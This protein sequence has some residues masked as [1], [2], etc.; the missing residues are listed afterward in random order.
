MAEFIANNTTNLKKLFLDRILY[1]AIFNLPEDFGEFFTNASGIKDYWSFENLLY[2][3]VDRGFIPIR[4]NKLS[5]IP[6][7][8]E[9][10]AYLLP[11]PAAAFQKMQNLFTQRTRAGA[12]A[13]DAYL[14]NI[15][16]FRAYHDADVDYNLY[17]TQLITNFNNSLISAQRENEIIDVKSYFERMFTYILES[18][19]IEFITRTAFYMSNKVSALSSG[20][21][22]EISD[23]DPSNNADKQ[24]FLDSP[25][26]EFYR[27][28]AVNFGFLI[29][30][31]IPWRLNFDLSSPVNK[32][33]LPNLFD[34]TSLADVYLSSRFIKLANSDITQLTSLM[35]V[36][37][38]TFV[39][40]RPV[41]REGICSFSRKKHT[42]EEIERDI[43]NSAYFLKKYIHI[44]NK[45]N[46][47]VYSNN[48]LEKIIFNATDLDTN[49]SLLYLESKFNLPYYFEGST[50][51]TLIK[52]KLST[53]K[54]FSLDKFDQHVKMLI[55]KKIESIY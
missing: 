26:F 30:K 55:K 49:A 52:K 34:G 53:N 1:E 11:E 6:L 25:N 16:I 19:E 54:D 48:E 7:S 18:A 40:K 14:N 41:R 8:K 31:N 47:L 43:F 12:L 13:E 39:E 27:E 21:S 45:E 37:Y 10:N 23:L 24:I 3:K 5:L 22:L 29:D 32:K 9:D 2:G 33:E 17:V 46:N 28:A 50:T 36:G 38:N 51:Y 15:K 42:I 44:K 35:L 4:V 20:M